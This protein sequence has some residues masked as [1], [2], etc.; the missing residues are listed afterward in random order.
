METVKRSFMLRRL[1]KR[2]L[3]NFVSRSWHDCIRA[4]RFLA[5][6]RREMDRLL[7]KTMRRVGSMTLPPALRPGRP[8]A[9]GAVPN[10]QV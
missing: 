8:H 6:D 10:W 1:Q 4:H 3:R 5:R 9:R 2:T 7:V